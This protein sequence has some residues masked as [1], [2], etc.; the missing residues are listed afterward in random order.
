MFVEVFFMIQLKELC[1]VWRIHENNSSFSSDNYVFL[2]LPHP[3]SHNHLIYSKN[4]KKHPL[5]A[6]LSSFFVF[7]A[8]WHLF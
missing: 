8:V 5:K 3:G 6:K 1:W 7:N 4:C 2:Q